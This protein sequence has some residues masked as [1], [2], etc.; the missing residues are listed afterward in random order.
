[1]TAYDEALPAPPSDELTLVSL[2]RTARQLSADFHAAGLT[3]DVA[4]HAVQTQQN[5][6]Q[7]Y[8]A[9][10]PEAAYDYLRLGALMLGRT[11]GIG[12]S[13]AQLQREWN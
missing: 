11:Q 12:R 4:L 9:D 13:L 7:R 2:L 3:D 6:T 10:G 1:M 8:Y 5:V